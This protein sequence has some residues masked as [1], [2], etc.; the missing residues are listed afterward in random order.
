M[1]RWLFL[2]VIIHRCQKPGKQ[3]KKSSPFKRQPRSFNRRLGKHLHLTQPCQHEQQE[4][5][6]SL[7][8]AG[9]TLADKFTACRVQSSQVQSGKSL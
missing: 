6:S 3:G 5:F 8:R 9:C 2:S 7:K 1:E 4:G